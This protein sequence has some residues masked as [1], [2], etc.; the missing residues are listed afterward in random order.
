[1]WDIGGQTIMVGRPFDLWAL[2]AGVLVAYFWAIRRERR[3][4]EPEALT[5]AATG[6][7]KFSFVAGIGAFLLVSGTPWHDIGE[8]ALFS[9]HTTEHIVHA[10]VVAPLLV[11]G[12]PGWMFRALV[13]V[14]RPRRV[15]AR[16]TNPITAALLFNA[17]FAL[18][19]WPA[20]VDAMLRANSLHGVV[21]FAWIGASV[22]MWLP[23]AS[24]DTNLVRRLSPPAQM[25]YLLVMTILPTVPSSFLTFGEAPMYKVYES[26]PR[27]WNIPAL[28]D[29]QISGLIMKI[30]GGFLLWGIITVKFFRWAAVENRKELG[31]RPSATPTSPDTEPVRQ[32]S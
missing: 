3:F 25:G 18:L 32:L 15:L 13:P 16:L 26:L 9:F 1:M 19:H 30:G 4:Q 12:V 24:P 20:I 7:Q 2:C 17:A 11:M 14:G 21:H 5:P 27:M 29:M 10:F 22:I 28:E 6:A 23:I 8:Q 31:R